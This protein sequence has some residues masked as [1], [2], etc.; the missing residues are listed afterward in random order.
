MRVSLTTLS[1]SCTRP[2][3]LAILEVV[4]AVTAEI[5]TDEQASAQVESTSDADD[6]VTTI[7]PSVLDDKG[8]AKMNRRDSIVK[9]LLGRG[10]DRV[11][12]L[13]VLHMAH[14]Q[15]VLNMEDGSQL[16]T[17]SQEELHTEVKVH[18]LRHPSDPCSI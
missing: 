11:V 8:D 4:S 13:L 15:I 2:T 16:A 5:G 12:F 7:N 9:G 1:F 17:L 6:L 3:L 10:K 14:A 18:F